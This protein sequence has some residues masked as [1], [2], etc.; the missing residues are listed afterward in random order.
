MP[1]L[2]TSVIVRPWPAKMT[3]EV[4]ADYCGYQGK[5][6]VSAFLRAVSRGYYPQPIKHPGEAQKWRKSDLDER[7]EAETTSA[8]GP[9][10]FE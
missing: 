10:E 9:I 8:H 6:A 2:E 5:R 3:A 4:A 7:I 1:A